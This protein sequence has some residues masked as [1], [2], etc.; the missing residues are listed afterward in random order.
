MNFVLD[1]E[2]FFC[3][4]DDLEVSFLLNLFMVLSGVI[5]D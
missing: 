3:F 5:S 4:C 1:L 2:V